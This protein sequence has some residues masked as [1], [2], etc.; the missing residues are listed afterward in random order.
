V[1]P[2]SVRALIATALFGVLAWASVHA[3]SPAGQAQP[4]SRRSDTAL[5]AA[6]ISAGPSPPRSMRNANYSIDVE[7]DPSTHTLS[8]REVITWRNVTA[9]PTSELQFHL[10]YNA[11]SNTQSTWLRERMRVED[12]RGA[13]RTTEPLERRGAD[14]WGW[15]DVTAVRLLAAAPAPF[16]ELTASRRFIAPDDGNQDDRTVMS[17]PLPRSVGPGESIALEVA[18]TAKVPRTFARTGVIGNFFFVAQWF[19]K[20]GVLQ[21]DGWKTPQFH[22]G[23]EFF[24]DYGVYDVRITVPRGWVVGA[25]GVEQQRLETPTGKTTHRYLQED[26]H[27]FAWTT[28][29]DLVDRRERFDYPGLPAVEM[30][31]LLQPEHVGQEARHFA[32]TR[33]TLQYYGQWFGP[34]PYGHITIVD[35]AWQS[36]AGGMEYPTLFTAG[37]R[38]LIRPGVTTPEGVTVHE[39][40]H[41]FWYGLVGNDEFDHAWMD[42]GLN[43][44]S[45]ARVLEQ[46]FQPDYFSERFFGGFVPWVYRDITLSRE[47]DGNRL[48]QYRGSATSDAQATPSWRYWPGTGANITYAKTALWLNTLERY[49]GWPRLQRGMSQYFRRHVFT[50]PEPRDFFAALTDAAGQ[51]LSWFFDQVYRSSNVVDYGIRRFSSTPV[52]VKGIVT[53]D[54]RRVFVDGSAKPREYVTELVVRRVGDA[55]LPVD[56]LVTFS[57]GER[58]HERW[59]GRDRWRLYRWRRGARARTAQ[60][61]PARVLLLDVDYTN[62]TWT[63]EPESDR[64]ARKWAGHWWLWL[65]DALLTWASVA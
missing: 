28:S 14:D 48:S 60:V 63:L 2:S 24:S 39:A 54:G 57:D 10:Y 38:W 21:S 22:M 36:A 61:D 44:F 4:S 17:V 16:T 56:L 19:P 32:A 47:T 50:H 35:P 46:A 49:I 62:N 58:A 33:A 40:G 42:E 34:Y 7:L 8:G 52:A 31:L 5:D 41:Q 26:V 59:D 64:A 37:T 29:P 15:M 53:I 18:W 20:L 43:T 30:R 27:D 6:P 12:A 45:T 1:S 3:A 25:T 11:W 13:Q 9:Q 55:V 51:D 65:Q 23:T